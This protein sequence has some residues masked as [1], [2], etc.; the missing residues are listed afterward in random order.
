MQ[1][2]QCVIAGDVVMVDGYTFTGEELLYHTAA[3]WRRKWQEEAA[4][5][6]QEWQQH[7]ADILAERKELS[8]AL[9]ARFRAYKSKQEARLQRAETALAAVLKVV[10]ETGSHELAAAAARAAEAALAEAPEQG[11]SPGAA[12]GAAVRLQAACRGMLARRALNNTRKLSPAMEHRQTRIGQAA[13]LLQRLLRGAHSRRQLKAAAAAPD[14]PPPSRGRAQSHC[15]RQRRPPRPGR[16][17][18][19]GHRG[20]ERHPRLL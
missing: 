6:E 17:G 7:Q 14:P 12:P 9:C 1:H 11:K 3:N 2:T 15:P 18:C 20:G 19:P 16:V 10:S 13:G 4:F 8:S 5:R